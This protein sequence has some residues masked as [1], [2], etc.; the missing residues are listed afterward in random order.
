MKQKYLDQARDWQ[1]TCLRERT[2]IMLKVDKK[3]LGAM[4]RKAR[5][6]TGMTQAEVAA[7]IGIIP[8]FV[9]NCENGYR[10]MSL[11]NLAKFIEA[12]ESV[13]PAKKNGE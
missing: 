8:Q 7:R 12:V 2:K 5:Q 3:L 4:L 9:T 13:K 11:E 1:K 6:D 10:M